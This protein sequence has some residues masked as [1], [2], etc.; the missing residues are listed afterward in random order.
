MYR[1][2]LFSKK[3]SWKT[4]CRLS[5]VNSSQKLSKNIYYTHNLII[6]VTL[7]KISMNTPIAIAVNGFSKETQFVGESISSLTYLLHWKSE[8]GKIYQ[9]KVH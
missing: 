2:V 6:S 3:W 8:P 5:L 7:F 9:K 4:S 1:I